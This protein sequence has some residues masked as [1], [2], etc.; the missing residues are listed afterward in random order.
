MEDF[1]EEFTDVV[2][3]RIFI[4]LEWEHVV[5]EGLELL[6]H[7]RAEAFFCSLHFDLFYFDS[8]FLVFMGF[9][10]LPGEFSLEKEDKDVADGFEVISSWGFKTFVTVNACVSDCANQ[11]SVLFELD[12]LACLGVFESFCKSQ[13]NHIE[14]WLSFSWAHEKVFRLDI[15]VNEAFFM[16]CLDSLKKLVSK[17]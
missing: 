7:V 15:S 13:V 6:G 17:H 12:V 16:K 2:I 5:E 11:A 10:T 3:V 14:C 9:Y 8:F 4:K 1:F